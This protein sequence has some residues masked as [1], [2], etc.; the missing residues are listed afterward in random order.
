MYSTAANIFQWRPIFCYRIAGG[1]VGGNRP[2]N[3]CRQR[4]TKM[5]VAALIKNIKYKLPGRGLMMF[6]ALDAG[7]VG[8]R[9]QHR[10]KNVLPNN[11]AAQIDRVFI[12]VE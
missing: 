4:T 6:S 3:F 1:G 11:Y 5:S 9:P 10:E 8:I 7:C 12:S 2:K